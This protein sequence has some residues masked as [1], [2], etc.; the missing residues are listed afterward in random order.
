MEG[1]R[2]PSPLMDPYLIASA[3]KLEIG[4]RCAIKIDCVPRLCPTI[5]QL[6]AF[7]F[8]PIEMVKKRVRDP[9]ILPEA[10]VQASKQDED[11]GSDEVN[12]HLSRHCSLADD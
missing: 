10:P 1:V 8:S 6:E 9:D 12:S 3:E 2:A 4:R 7:Y 11:S 5:L